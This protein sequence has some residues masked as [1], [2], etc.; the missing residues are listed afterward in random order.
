MRDDGMHDAMQELL[1]S[2]TG[3]NIPPTE[4]YVKVGMVAMVLRNLDP[5]SKLM[6]GSK[7]RIE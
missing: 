7:V 3:E 5:R 2:A 4:L 1:D 6:N